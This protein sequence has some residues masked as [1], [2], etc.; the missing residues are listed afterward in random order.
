MSR[1]NNV[2]ATLEGGFTSEY[3]HD[4]ISINLGVAQYVFDMIY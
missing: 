3:D 1:L 4:Y 2:I